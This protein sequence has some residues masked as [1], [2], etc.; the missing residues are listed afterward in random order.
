MGKACGV[1][2]QW[3]RKVYRFLLVVKPACKRPLVRRRPRQEG[4]IKMQN[5]P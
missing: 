1:H 4:N 3:N 5:G 2:E